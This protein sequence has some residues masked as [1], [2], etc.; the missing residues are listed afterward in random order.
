MR[1]D[2][3]NIRKVR[4]NDREKLKRDLFSPFKFS[5]DLVI[6]L[7][8]SVYLLKFLKGQILMKPLN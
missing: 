2:I 8:L 7:A 6:L 3:L 1:K 5:I 4:N